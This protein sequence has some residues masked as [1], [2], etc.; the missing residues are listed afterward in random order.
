[1]P[2]DLLADGAA[3]RGE[4]LAAQASRVAMLVLGESSAR[5]E[6]RA[7]GG[8][9]PDAPSMHAVVRDALATIDTGTLLGLDPARATHLM[10][11]GRVTWQ[12][13]AGAARAAASSSGKRGGVPRGF[14]GE[15]RVDEAPYGVG[16]LV[17]SWNPQ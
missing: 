8:F 17:V 4:G 12:V 10:V 6:A 14:R 15:L 7:P 13:A 9:D 11:S 2:D 16:Y 3:G 5:L 1:V